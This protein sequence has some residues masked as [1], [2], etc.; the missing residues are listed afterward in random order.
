MLDEVG[1]EEEHGPLPGVDDFTKPNIAREGAYDRDDHA[2]DHPSGKQHVLL[3]GCSCFSFDVVPRHGKPMSAIH[4]PNVPGCKRPRY[5]CRLGCIVLTRSSLAGYFHLQRGMNRLFAEME[6]EVSWCECSSGSACAAACCRD[7]LTVD[8]CWQ[9]TATRWTS[10]SPANPPT[11]SS[12]RSP[13]APSRPSQV[14]SRSTC[15][16]SRRSSLRWRRRRS[17]TRRRRTASP[18]E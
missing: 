16:A 7:A 4:H 1:V 10:P 3:A 2:E 13:A 6:P 15:L 17:R 5:R 12:S 11:T 18:R 8:R 9:Q 14:R